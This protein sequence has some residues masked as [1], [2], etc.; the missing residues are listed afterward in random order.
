M[1]LFRYA[2][3]FPDLP[4]HTSTNNHFASELREWHTKA[5]SIYEDLGYAL[6][7]YTE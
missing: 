4:G 1:R 7:G 3:Y 6:H 2:S 5:L